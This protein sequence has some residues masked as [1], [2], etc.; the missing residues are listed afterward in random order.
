M[1]VKKF[2]IKKTYDDA[3]NLYSLA[4]NSAIVDVETFKLLTTLLSDKELK[5]N[6]ADEITEH[7][8]NIETCIAELKHN[9]IVS[10]ELP[11]LKEKL[12]ILEGKPT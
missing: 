9:C 6:V 10:R 5:A 1:K 2:D 4:A 8:F 12:L 11:D 3:G 7:M